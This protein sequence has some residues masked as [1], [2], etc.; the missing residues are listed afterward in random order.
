MR[1]SIKVEKGQFGGAAWRA[2]ERGPEKAGK[3]PSEAPPVGEGQGKAVCPGEPYSRRAADPGLPNAQIARRLFLT[4][5]TL[6]PAL[7]GVGSLDRLASME[8]ERFLA[9]SRVR[10]RPA[11]DPPHTG[12]FTG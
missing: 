11:D 6:N 7:R 4:S 5:Q 3:G 9:S 2:C 1:G 8:R 12:P 10:G